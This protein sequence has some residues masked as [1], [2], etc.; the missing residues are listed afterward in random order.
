MVGECPVILLYIF[1]LCLDCFKRAVDV[2]FRRAQNCLRC[3]VCRVGW[4]AKT[5]FWLC[6][7]TSVLVET[8]ISS[9]RA[10]VTFAS[11][12]PKLRAQVP[13]VLSSPFTLGL[14]T[15]GYTAVLR[16]TRNFLI[17]SQH[18]EI[19][20]M[21]YSLHVPYISILHKSILLLTIITA[22]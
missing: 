10:E 9:G 3:S 6:L 19:Y 1:W 11:F 7:A 8:L 18:T 21:L 15:S 13:S 22:G 14:F 16:I 2:R 5:F 17:F 4:S 20:A 12:C